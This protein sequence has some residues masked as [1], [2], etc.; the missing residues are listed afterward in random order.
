M[1]F[2]DAT[3]PEI[4]KSTTKWANRDPTL[5]NSLRTVLGRD[6]LPL[7]YI[8]RLSK[9]SDPT[10]NGYFLENYVSMAAVNGETF[11]INAADAHKFIVK[12]ISGNET[13]EA[14]KQS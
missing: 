6:F 10:P 8:C 14:K 12:F 5:F 13:S 7:K 4:F 2:S 3:K 9:A 11:M 1:T